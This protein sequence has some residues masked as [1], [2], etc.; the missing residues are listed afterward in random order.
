MTKPPHI[1]SIVG[2]LDLA[3]V[4]CILVGIVILLKIWR[5]NFPGADKLAWLQTDVSK[6]HFIERLIYRHHR[7]VGALLIAAAGFWL[8]L[9]STFDQWQLWLHLSWQYLRQLFH[10]G[11]LLWLATSA[12]AVLVL[13]F[14]VLLLLRPSLLKPVESAA[15]RW[16]SLF[17]SK[18]H[19]EASPQ[20]S[21]QSSH[22]SWLSGA[23]ALVVM[24][25]L[26][27]F[28]A[29]QLHTG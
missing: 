8:W 25:G 22:R 18:R 12:V 24:G 28:S 19:Q 27:L 17:E 7:L 21:K 20:T 6:P 3:G 13:V 15:N 10:S 16:V 11:V 1:S 29:T 5:R 26:L 4:L 2:L 23:L 9:L 14:G